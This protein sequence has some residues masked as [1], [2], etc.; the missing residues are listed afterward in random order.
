MLHRGAIRTSFPAESLG[1]PFLGG[2]SSLNDSDALEQL[3]RDRGDRIAAV[4]LEPIMGNCGSI[5]LRRLGAAAARYLH[6]IWGDAH[7]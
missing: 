4:L 2:L 1:H 5:A 3:F 7:H 6:P